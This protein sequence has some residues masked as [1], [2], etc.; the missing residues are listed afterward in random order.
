M[1]WK[2]REALAAA[3]SLPKTGMA[4]TIDT[5]DKDYHPEDKWDVG[6]RLSLLARRLVYGQDVECSGPAVE[7]C[8]GKAG[9]VVLRFGHATGLVDRDEGGASGFEVSGAEGVWD[10]GTAKVEGRE[11]W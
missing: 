3:L 11:W 8:E 1:Y 2:F 5:G 4:V 9:G 6:K 10:W 7:S